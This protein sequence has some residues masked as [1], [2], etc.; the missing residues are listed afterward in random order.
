M[1]S[2][3]KASPE[4]E[5][6]PTREEKGEK[7]LDNPAY[8]PIEMMSYK[9]QESKYINVSIGEI[10]VLLHCRYD[11]E[12]VAIYVVIWDMFTAKQFTHIDM[13]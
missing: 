7:M 1:K 6:P 5:G 13:M 3:V 4:G 11:V 12:M 10:V 8:L 9:S 2:S